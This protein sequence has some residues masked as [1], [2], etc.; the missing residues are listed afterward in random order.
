VHACPPERIRA[1]FESLVL[2]TLRNKGTGSN[3]GGVT[4]L[5]LSPSSSCPFF[6]NFASFI[7]V[8]CVDRA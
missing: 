2:F 5:L 7:E 8:Y 3:F 1:S 4:P 6:L